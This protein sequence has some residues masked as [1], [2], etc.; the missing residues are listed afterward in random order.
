MRLTFEPIGNSWTIFLAVA[1]MCL[2][3]L[4][5]PIR[6]GSIPPHRQRFLRVFRAVSLVL[7]LLALLRPSLILLKRERHS[8]VVLFLVDN[9]RSMQVM[10]GPNGS[11]R[12]EHV[13]QILKAHASALSALSTALEV[14]AYTFGREL[15]PIQLTNGE[16][17]LS[18]P[19]EQ[20][21][22]ALAWSL[23]EALRRE[24]GRRVVSIIL[25]TDGAQRVTGTRD[26]PVHGIAT[27]LQQQQIPVLSV[28]LG[29]PRGMGR[30]S[31]IS[32]DSLRA[33]AAAVVDDEVVV[34][35]TIHV[36]GYQGRQ[37][38]VELWLESP[39]QGQP[40]CSATVDV[41][42][43]SQA[44][45]VQLPF[46]PKT[47][48]EFKL[49]V[50][51][52]TQPGETIAL[53]NSRATI[54]RVTKGRVRVLIVDSF[55]PRPELGFLRRA[56][57]LGTQL[58]ID[59]LTLDPKGIPSQL[60]AFHRCLTE[61]EYQAVILGN[62]PS[63]IV[64]KNDW[65]MLCRKVT[66]GMGLLMIGGMWSFGPGGYADTPLAEILPVR[67]SHLEIQRPDEPPRTDVH[68]P[69][70]VKVRPTSEGTSH[71]MID[72]RELGQ[73]NQ[74]IW[75]R[76]PAL[77]GANKFD[78]LKPAAQ[79]LLETSERQPVLV[80]QPAGKGR[81]AA[82]AVDSTWR[83]ALAG[84]PEF[85]RLFWRTIVTFL[86]NK[87]LVREGRVWIDLAERVYRPN[88]PVDFFVG[89]DL[90]EDKG[91][92]EFSAQLQQTKQIVALEP[93]SG[94]RGFRGTVPSP[95]APGDYTVL[96]QVRQQD[97]LLEEATARFLVV[98]E[99]I[100]LGNPAADPTLLQ[101][102]ATATGGEVVRP[103]EFGRL[104]NRLSQQAAQMEATLEVRQPLWDRWPW[105]TTVLC[106][107][108]L[109][110]FFRRRWGL[111]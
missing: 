22:S 80:Y 110:W 33:P 77:D 48:G 39:A 18:H 5:V 69:G 7:L 56:L 102:L 104:L 57:T 23:E 84:Y 45:A 89:H 8:G 29:E 103:E 52:P 42:S 85:F 13:R 90:P 64:D 44:C 76:L 66:E 74:M 92:L 73:Q 28:L 98:E 55:P 108:S 16:S 32:V 35:T 46:V 41:T 91:R 50:R 83:W 25:L 47:P 14:R 97:K 11:S 31:D 93:R 100:E 101:L 1:G 79:V 60:G 71:P 15:M 109:E 111:V 61:R 68:I 107:V 95:T 59:I 63:W 6:A 87:D 17:L 54:L 10:D 58:E 4:F 62:I 99:D 30:F 2:A 96:V 67:M 12:F 53:N 20:P 26:V 49:V 65:E 105:L 81:V 72:I 40:L 36:E 27:Q 21:E 94:E 19:P 24:A 75:D 82:L 78:S 88:S 70:P 37:I 3:A 43:V 9:S 34:S 38:P 51:V 86:A 106:L